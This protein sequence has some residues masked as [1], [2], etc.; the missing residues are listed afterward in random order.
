M[1]NVLVAPVDVIL[2]VRVRVV[3]VLTHAKSTVLLDVVQGVV[4]NV[5]QNVSDVLYRAETN[6]TTPV[7]MRVLDAPD[8]AHVQGIA[9]ALAVEVVVCNVLA[10]VVVA[11]KV[12]VLVNV[13]DATLSV[14]TVPVH[15]LHHAIQHAPLPVVRRVLLLVILHVRPHVVRNV[16]TN[17]EIGASLVAMLDVF[18]AVRKTV[19]LHAI[20]TARENALERQNPKLLLHLLSIS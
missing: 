16:V 20:V 7:Q 11:V 10:A 4:P 18:P 3:D 14:Q 1:Q 6:V 12:V 13:Q 2:S 19:V 5:R 8:V 15:A 17:A 9:R